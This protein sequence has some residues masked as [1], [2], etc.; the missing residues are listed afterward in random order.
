MGLPIVWLSHIRKKESR[1]SFAKTVTNALHSDTVIARLRQLVQQKIEVVDQDTTSDK[2]FDTHAWAYW[3]AN[4]DGKM[5][6]YREVL[7]LLETP[8]K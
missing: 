5:T 1:D 3:R 4:V 2:Q 8:T 7:K 6:A